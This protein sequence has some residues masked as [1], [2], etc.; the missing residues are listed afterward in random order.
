MKT[1]LINAVSFY[2]SFYFAFYF[3]KVYLR[4]PAL[5]GLPA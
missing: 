4:F 3:G 1:N 5:G 2:F